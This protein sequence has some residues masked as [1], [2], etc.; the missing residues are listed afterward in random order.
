MPTDASARPISITA[1]AYETVSAPAPPYSSGNGRPSKPSSPILRIVASGNSAFA[2]HSCACGAT[3]PS[4]NSRHSLAT[5]S[6]SGVRSKSMAPRLSQSTGPS[7]PDRAAR[8]GG[9]YARTDGH[10]PHCWLCVGPVVI[11]FQDVSL[12]YPNGVHVFTE[13]SLTVARGEFLFLVGSSGQGKSSLL[14]CVNLEVRP[15]EGEVRVDGQLLG[16]LHL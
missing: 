11:V 5:S 15:T 9:E 2:S 1:S 6:C 4:A 16:D 8:P 14:K 12:V 10:Y 13:V 3:S 7:P